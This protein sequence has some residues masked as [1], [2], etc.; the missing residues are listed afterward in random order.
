MLHVALGDLL[1]LP[2]AQAALSTGASPDYLLDA[3][4]HLTDAKG[5]FQ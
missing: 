4:L 5:S 1:D 2:K 3:F